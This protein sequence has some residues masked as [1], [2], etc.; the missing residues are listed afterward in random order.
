MKSEIMEYQILGFTSYTLLQKEVNKYLRK[1]M[2]T[3]QWEPLGGV[4]VV[5]NL[6]NRPE[7]YQAMI[8]VKM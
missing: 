7:Y 6:M 2:L 5:Q 3:E 8:R 4:S 1:A